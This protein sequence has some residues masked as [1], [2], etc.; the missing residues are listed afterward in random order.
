MIQDQRASI[1][2]V[3][4]LPAG[5]S[6]PTVLVLSG[7]DDARED[8]ARLLHYIHSLRSLTTLAVERAMRDALLMQEG[9]ANATRPVDDKRLRLLIPPA[10]SVLAT[11]VDLQATRVDVH[12]ANRQAPCCRNASRS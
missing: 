1:T 3:Q 10:G 2:R 4:C 5:N 7:R 9:E 12:C 11:R 6:V 8:R